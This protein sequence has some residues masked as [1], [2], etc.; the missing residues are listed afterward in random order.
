MR[1]LMILGAV[2]GGMLA[3]PGVASAAHI[4]GATYTGPISSSFSQPATFSMTVSADGDTLDF[5][6]SNFGSMSCNSVT[7]GPVTE[8]PISN[9]S[10]SYLSDDGQNSASGG[11][12]SPGTAGGGVQVLITPC[13]TGS[14]SWTAETDVVWPDALIGRSTDSALLGDDVYNTTAAGQTRRWSAKRRRARRFKLKIENDGT[15]RGRLDVRGCNSS[16]PFTV[17]YTRGSSDI[18][19]RVVGGN[20]KTANLDPDEAEQILLKI[21]VARR[22]RIGRTKTCKVTTSSDGVADAVVAKL[23]VKRG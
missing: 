23:R 10:F 15:E 18:T 16:G 17:T 1:K 3:M 11:F 7:L 4:P 14:H 2:A 20:Y 12:T 19:T 13:T 6:A 5:T 21:R 8:V 9:H 22:A